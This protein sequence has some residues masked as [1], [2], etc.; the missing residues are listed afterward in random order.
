MAKPIQADSVE[1]LQLRRVML[2]KRLTPAALGRLAK[3]NPRRISN[4]L[5]GTDATWPIRAAINRALQERLFSKP[6]RTAPG[7]RPSPAHV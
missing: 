3:F 4:V 1:I 6:N 2:E 5:C 7:R